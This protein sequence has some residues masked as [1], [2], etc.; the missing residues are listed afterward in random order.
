MGRIYTTIQGE[1][2]DAV[3][4]KIYGDE[5]GYVERVLEANPGLARLPHRLPIGTKIHLPDLS[6]TNDSQ[7]VISLWD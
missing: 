2:L 7:S 1:M 3:C 6:R 4:Q 5:S